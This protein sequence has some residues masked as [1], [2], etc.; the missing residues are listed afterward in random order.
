MTTTDERV[1]LHTDILYPVVRVRTQKSGGSG[2]VIACLPDPQHEGESLT[3]VLTN[4]H[5]IEDAVKTKKDWDSL[6]KREVEKEFLSPVGVE[7]FQYVYT[8][9]VNSSDSYKAQIVAYDKHQDIA[10]LKLESPRVCH[11]VVKLY[12]KGADRDIV[13]FTDMYTVGCS[14][15]HDPFATKGQVT[16]KDE[17][18]DNEQFWMGSSNIIFGNSGGATFLADTHEFIGIPARVTAL[19]FG[20]SSDVMTFMGLFIP[21]SRIYDFFDQQELAFLYDPSAPD[22]YQSME[23]RKKLQQQQQGGP[24]Q[25]DLIDTLPPRRG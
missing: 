10:V 16:Y 4:A 20:F 22:Y 19:N 21:I 8:S 17:L 18:V 5:V 25:I 7:I 15:G 13:L 14:I 12:P 6:L 3:F 9:K 23:T 11:H 1:Q 2:T 24:Q